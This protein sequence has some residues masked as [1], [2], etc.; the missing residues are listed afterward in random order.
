MND[1]EKFAYDQICDAL[2]TIDAQSTADIYVLSFYIYDVND[3]PRRPVLQFGYNTRARLAECTPADDELPGWPV[4]SNAQEAKWNFAFWLQNELTSV[5]ET[6]SE[7]ERLLEAALKAKALW[8]SDEDEETD[9]DGCDKFARG[10]T[11]YFVDASVRIARALHASGVIEQRFS[12]AIPIVVHELEYYDQI[13]LQ[14]RL[15]NPP[16][17]AQEFEDWIANI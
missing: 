8:Y 1:F 15:A 6:G 2:A 14:T 12:I 13:G 9:F 16:G 7:G 3:D 5:G 4:A 10:I 17:I 11:D